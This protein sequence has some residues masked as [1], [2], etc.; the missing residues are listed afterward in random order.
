MTPAPI[1]LFVFNRPSHTLRLLT[2]LR[3][4]RLSNQSRLFVYADGPKLHSTESEI[5]KIEEVRKIIRSEK[6]C[7]DIHLVE[8]S[9]NLGLADSIVAG[10]SEL[11]NSYGKVIVL[12]DDLVLSHGFLEYMNAALDVF[13]KEEKVMHISGYMFPVKNKLPE[14][15]FLNLTS[16]WG[17]GTWKR[18]WAHYNPSAEDLLKKLNASG[19]LDQFTFNNTAPFYNHLLANTNGQLKTWAIKWLTTIFLENGF[20]LHPFPSLVRNDGNDGTGTHGSEP[21]F[22]H[23]RIDRKSVV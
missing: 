23:Q 19:R 15:F 11:I 3:E 4:C 1:V 21:V 6:W 16:C 5:R 22:Q 2:S 9:S 20:C 13:E 8:R 17:W 18:A 14:L 7:K 12:E 10:V